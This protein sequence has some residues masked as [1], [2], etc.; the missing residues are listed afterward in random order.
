MCEEAA[1]IS[2]VSSHIAASQTSYKRKEWKLLDGKLVDARTC[3][4]L[5]KGQLDMNLF[6]TPSTLSLI[7]SLSLPTSTDY[8]EHCS[9]CE[10]N[11]VNA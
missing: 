7:I 6:I 1:L 9:D 8:R 11:N 10:H 4:M 3:C 2:T 5:G